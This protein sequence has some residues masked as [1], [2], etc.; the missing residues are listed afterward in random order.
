MATSQKVCEICKFSDRNDLDLGEWKTSEDCTIHLFCALLS[1]NAVQ[2]GEDNEGIDGFL[3]TDIR[4]F[5]K[6]HKKTKCYYCKK[7]CATVRCKNKKCPRYFHVKCGTENNCLF[8]FGGDSYCHCH[9][10]IKEK[11]TIH[12][13]YWSCQICK[14]PMGPYNPI[15]S[16]PS[17]CNQGFFHRTCIQKH[18]RA[19]G[20]LTKCPC[21]GNGF[22]TDNNEY[23]QFLAQRGIFCPDKDADWE[24]SQDAYHSL[25]Y[26]HNQCDA[27]N[28]LCPNGRKHSARGE[29]RLHKCRYCG[30]KGI[31]NGCRPTDTNNDFICNDC[32]GKSTPLITV[33]T[34]SSRN[35][36]ETTNEANMDVENPSTS[37]TNVNNNNSNEPNT[38]GPGESEGKVFKLVPTDRLSYRKTTLLLADESTNEDDDPLC[39]AARGKMRNN[40]LD[41]FFAKADFDAKPAPPPWLI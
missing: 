25:L 15:T 11:N 27:R 28:C 26:V 22:D 29:W 21:C 23:R 18:A 19:A 10:D 16:I 41:M 37:K 39:G 40:R 30:E 5:V 24:L 1:P 35:N 33:H 34:E 12:G 3:V 31:H 13:D 32:S 14:E 4:D 38:S 8:Q 7:K 36:A 2:R 20:Y 6:L 9:V 17:C